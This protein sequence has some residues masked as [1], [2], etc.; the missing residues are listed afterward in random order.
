MSVRDALRW[1]GNWVLR[2]R[3]YRILHC[4]GDSHARM[5]R[6]LACDS[7]FTRTAFRVTVVG[8]ATAMGVVNPNSR[9][10]ALQ[11]FRSAL[12]GVPP[13]DPVLTLLGEVD[14]GFVIWY[15]AMKY[16]EPVEAQLDASL[17]RYQEFLR[18]LQTSGF[19][20][21][22]VCSAPLPTIADGQSWG[23]V[24]N[25]RREVH[26]SQLER[27][28]LTRMYNRRMADFAAVAGIEFIDL[29]GDLRDPLTG[30]IRSKFLNDD[31][32]DHHLNDRLVVPLIGQRLRD[33]GYR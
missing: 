8:G 9:T 2:L 18:G 13:R 26:V 6:D 14:C 32:L 17:S 23:E 31:P 1:T 11:T 4:L 25:A 33:L 24:A 12:R 29:D 16:G 7:G 28:D 21:L 19:E 27:T 15:R 10:N 30:L 5:F 3:G 22:I 20:R